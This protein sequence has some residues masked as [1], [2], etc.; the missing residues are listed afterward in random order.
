MEA[1]ELPRIPQAQYAFVL[2]SVNPTTG[3][4]SE[5][6]GEV[7]VGQGEAL[8][9]NAPGRAFGFACV[10]QAGAQPVV[11]SLP[12]KGAALWGKGW[13]FRSDSNC[14]DLPGFAGAGLFDSYPVVEHASSVVAYRKQKLVSDT[15]FARELMLKLKDLAQVVEEKMGGVPQDIEGCFLDGKLYVV[16]TRPQVGLDPGL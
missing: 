12:S 13:I 6:Y 7:V 2:H 15:A 4:A 14:E 10:K 5:M 3:D 11:K 9:G 1:H 16:Q 8:V